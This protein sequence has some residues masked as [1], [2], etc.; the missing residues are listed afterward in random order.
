M[1]VISH[2]WK[3]FLP[4]HQTIFYLK[5]KIYSGM[6]VA[7][8]F[9]RT[10]EIW[11]TIR[12]KRIIIM[13][14]KHI[15][16][17]IASFEQP[18]FLAFNEEHFDISTLSGTSF[19]DV[20]AD[21]IAESN[22]SERER[23]DSSSIKTNDRQAKQERTQ[24]YSGLSRSETTDYNFDT[25][26]ETGST[27]SEQ[28]TRTENIPEENVS[29]HR[30][31][32]VRDQ[33]ESIDESSDRVV[34]K[35]TTQDD[36][37]S[38]EQ[39]QDTETSAEKEVT[40]ENSD[41]QTEQNTSTHTDSI[42]EDTVLITDSNGNVVASNIGG[43][44]SVAGVDPK[45]DVSDGLAKSNFDVDS[46]QQ[47]DG[48]QEP[49]K[50]AG[51]TPATEKQ[52]SNDTPSGTE[53]THQKEQTAAQTL[54]HRE[55]DQL[56]IQQIA[57]TEQGTKIPTQTYS[58]TEVYPKLPSSHP[59]EHNDTLQ[60]EKQDNVEKV[61]VETDLSNGFENSPD[62]SGSTGQKGM[63]N[64]SNS[65]RTAQQDTG[66]KSDL[67]EIKSDLNFSV[68]SAKQ[69]SKNQA[70]SA[71]TV[72]KE[73]NLF[74]YEDAKLMEKDILQQIQN[75]I[76]IRN[77]D[78]TRY[79]EMNFRLKP[80]SLGSLSLKLVMDNDTLMA[81][82]KVDND[83]VR[84]VI[85]NSLGE[86]RKSLQTQG[87]KVEKVEVTLRNDAENLDLSQDGRQQRT[88]IHN[89]GKHSYTTKQAHNSEEENNND[90][91]VQTQRISQP[92]H[93]GHLDYLI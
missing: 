1:V 68:D 70:Q 51:T 26:S 86:L 27:R 48:S 3:N 50:S 31:H 7:N 41:Q 79:S 60:T 23:F 87:V 32:D 21:T 61:T 30:S 84:Q 42:N 74:R 22:F 36:K 4:I 76:Q 13:E 19:N 59:G 35:D 62:D 9:Y 91:T 28:Q 58:N 5:F 78:G 93:E 29:T 25:P 20:L 44:E 83:T 65:I 73:M 92:L 46:M 37:G 8:P 47:G 69:G 15:D 38:T 90:G 55:T 56:N 64:F 54:P 80:E 52:S 11:K 45:A 75:K 18:F 24:V 39:S 14:L 71:Q 6:Q 85:E 82:I 88:G 16:F 81:K 2:Y 40:Q 43:A 67:E 63:E 49:Q 77:A 34:E 33:V 17:S 66:T 89:R 57:E 10:I 53:E 12:G 72:E